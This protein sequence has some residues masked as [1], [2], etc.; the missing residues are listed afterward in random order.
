VG[1]T[2]QLAPG[3]RCQDYSAGAAWGDVSG[4]GVL[5]LFIAQHSGPSELWVNQGGTFVERA[6]QYGV[7]NR[8]PDGSYPVGIGATFIDYDAD[9]RL[10]LFVINNGLNRLYRNAPDGFVDVAGA[11]GL[12]D[13]ANHTSAAWGDYD[14]DGDLDLYVTS[15]GRRVDCTQPFSY[16]QDRLYRND[17]AGTFTDVSSFLPDPAAL[18]GLGFQGS[19]FDYNN[20][21]RLDLH[22]SNDSILQIDPKNVLWRNDGPGPGGSWRFTNVSVSSGAGVRANAMGTGIGDYDRNGF[23]D[24]TFSDLKPISLLANQGDGTF[25]N[26]AREVGLNRTEGDEGIR[27]A[28]WGI[29]F[30]DFNADGW[31]DIYVAAGSFVTGDGP[32]TPHPNQLFVNDGAG[33]FLD[34]SG[35][36]H[37]DDPDAGRGVAFADY[38]RDGRVDMF[39]LNQDGIPRLFRNVT[40]GFGHWLHVRVTGPGGS[41]ACGAR[42]S[43]LDAG[44]PMTRQVLCGSTSLSSGTDPVVRLGLG[45]QLSAVIRVDWP[46]GATTTLEDVPADQ[47]IVVP[48]P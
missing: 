8:N 25:T 44:P 43:V 29:T 41:D 6:A 47:R 39:V 30:E 42:L 48:M 36:S 15:H 21:G 14:G 45:A 24:I 23:F 32:P 2:T 9:G 37:A 16:F 17:G 20:D 19:W 46:H 13:D 7:Q 40:Q 22:I 5:D 12:T 10:D 18:M 31:E 35:P 27:E 1:L 34:L 28:T 33:R 26:V 4:D 38:D 11:A 3:N